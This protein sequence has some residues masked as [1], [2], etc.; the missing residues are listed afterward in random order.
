MQMATTVEALREIVRE[1]EPILRQHSQEAE[2][3]RQLSDEV[4]AAMRERRLYRLWRPR[5]FGGLEVDPICLSS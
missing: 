1:I 4:V 3:A 2:P 5:A